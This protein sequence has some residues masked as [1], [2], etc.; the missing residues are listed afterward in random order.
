MRGVCGIDIDKDKVFISL[1]SEQRREINFLKEIEIA[2]TDGGFLEYLKK[3]SETLDRVIK[4]EEKRLSLK[5]EDIFINLP[6]QWEKKRLVED[7]IP[8]KR[9]KKINPSDLA[10]AKRRIADIFLDWDDFCIHNFILNCEIDG[11]MY[12][13][14][15]LGVEAKKVRMKA[16][17]VWVKDKLRKEVEDVFDNLDRNFSGFICSDAS[18]LAASFPQGYVNSSKNTLCVLNIG[19]D[20]SDFIVY[21][22][23]ALDFGRDFDFGEKKIIQAI[24]K[25]FLLS[26]SLA[27]EVFCRYISFKNVPYYK[28]ISIKKENTYI[29]L[30][31]QAVNSFV[32]EYI[33]GELNFILEKIKQKINSNSFTLSFIGRLT[34]KEGFF[35]FVKEFFSSPIEVIL[36]LCRKSLSSSFGCLKYGADRFLEF[37][38]NRESLPFWQRFRNI[39]K[40][41]F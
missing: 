29:N 11:N 17:L 34:G 6:R 26:S 37:E 20:S 15:P 22:E 21:K 32:R 13:H 8:L 28:E 36:P 10:A 24:E 19:Y 25:R 1:A 7:V 33:K 2:H 16:L 41:Y 35:S 3:N 30:S 31:T 9:R 18:S 38:Y 12:G 27:K 40:E 5:V 4:E 14:L 23:G 39:Y